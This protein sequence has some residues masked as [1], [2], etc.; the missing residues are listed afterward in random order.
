[1]HG[2]SPSPADDWRGLLDI[3]EDLDNDTVD[4]QIGRKA[5]AQG[6]RITTSQLHAIGLDHNAIRHRVVTGRLIKEHREVYRVGY[7]APG[8]EGRWHG[9]LCAVR[10]SALSFW[11]ASSKLELWYSDYPKVHVTV[12]GYSGRDHRDDIRVHRQ[13]L[14]ESHVME[15]DGLRVT[16]VARTVV[17]MAFVMRK[18]LVH[19]LDR[20]E[21]R[22]DFDLV[23]LGQV[24]GAFKRRKGIPALRRLIDVRHPD[25][26]LLDTALERACLDLFAG[27][28]P[29]RLQYVINDYRADFAWEDLRIIVEVDGFEWHKTR[30][31]ANKDA[32]KALE[33]EAE[34]WRVLRLTDDQVYWQPDW[35]VATITPIFQRSLSSSS[36]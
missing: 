21:R 20:A 28:P 36:G 31:D 29:C 23:K 14:P 30:A 18:G 4:K 9:A 10:R 1:M 6:G 16:T 26:S 33:L 8:R 22:E 17:D 11:D 13:R 5:S 3:P 19:V 7:K 24:I 32:K 25:A 27:L 34:G 15:L 2:S 12:D 35:V